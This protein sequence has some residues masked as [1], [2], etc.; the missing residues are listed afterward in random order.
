MLI[1]SQKQRFNGNPKIELGEKEMYLKL[2]PWCE[3]NAEQRTITVKR[4][5]FKKKNE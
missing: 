3:K 2:L 5:N 1:G 4:N